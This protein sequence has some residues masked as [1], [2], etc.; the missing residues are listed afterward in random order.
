MKRFLSLAIVLAI[1]CSIFGT[2]PAFAKEDTQKGDLLANG[3][4]E[5][6]GTPYAFWQGVADNTRISTSITHGGER[7]M[8]LYS[9]DATRQIVIYDVEG[10]I[11]GKNYVFSVYL[12]IKQL[13]NL[14]EIDNGGCIKIE[15]YDKEGNGLPGSEWGCFNGKPEK[16]FEC[17]L[18]SIAPDNANTAKIQLR[19]ECGG[20]I[21]WDDASFVG[22]VPTRI[23]EEIKNKR[24][25]AAST[26]EHSS[27]LLKQEQQKSA[28]IQLAPGIANAIKNPGFEELTADGKAPVNWRG[29]KGVWGQVTFPTEEE[30]HSG[31]R[32]AKITYD[33]PNDPNIYFPY[34]HHLITDNLVGGTD[35]VLSAWV[36]VKDMA[37]LK[38]IVFKWE[39][40][41]GLEANSQNYIAAGDSSEYILEEG[42]WHQVKFSFTLP[43][44][45][46]TLHLYIRSTGPGTVYYDDI[47]FGPTG[48]SAAMNFYTKDTFYYTEDK[49]IEAFA[50]INYINHPIEDGNVVDFV[51]KDG[52]SVVAE[53]TIPAVPSV[54]AEFDVMTLAEKGKKYTIS[55]TY[56]KAD[57]TVI[58][59]SNEKRIYRYDRPTALNEKGEYIDENG[60][61]IDVIYL[62]GGFEEFFD[63]YQKAGITVIRIDDI[64]T[65]NPGKIDEIRKKLDAAHE[66]GLKVLY[67]LYGHAAGHP[68]QIPTTKLLVEEFKDHPAIFGWM[69]VDEPCY[70]VG[71]GR[72]CQTYTEILEYLEEGYRVIREIDPVHPVY[73]IEST[74]VALSYEKAF[75]YV[76]VAGIDIYPTPDV[77]THRTSQAARRAVNAVYGEKPVWNLGYASEWMGWIPTEEEFRMSVISAFW[78]GADGAGFYVEKSIA[79]SLNEALIKMN[80][81]GERHQLFN[82]FVREKSP[83]FSE[84][85]GY[86]YWMRSW[87]DE[88]KLYI[89]LREHKNDGKE[90]PVSFKVKSTNGLIELNGFNARLVN[91]PTAP[92]VSS[93]D[94]T[95]NLTLKPLETATYVI[96]LPAGTDASLLDKPIYNDLGN[97]TW[98]IDAIEKT[99][100]RGVSNDKGVG[101]YAPGEN[102]T[103]G[104]FAMYLVRT[105]G[106]TEYDEG[107]QFTDV[108]PNAYYAKEIA[109]GKKAGILKGTGDGTYHPEEPISRQDLMVICARGLRSLNKISTANPDSALKNFSD[110]GLIADYALVEVASMV[111]SGKITGNADMTINPLGNTTR[112]EAAVIMSRIL[113]Y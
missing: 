53:Q 77:A 14:A 1:I 94:S 80:E 109:I 30:A 97:H 56:K 28:D 41:S 13:L 50:D 40:Y 11:P 76:D 34:M 65:S 23:Y 85:I 93:A 12:Y 47:E 19:M 83:V 81:S 72:Q 54:K 60:N 21:F 102:I 26:W 49:V 18:E 75:Q 17:T 107:D 71:M 98:A 45:T 10:V 35:Y 25:L 57:G 99:A 69:M 20:E 112:A 6:L 59:E 84:Y 79:P 39:A 3:D 27:E 22:E 55:A 88:G 111:A 46:A 32:S 29:Y 104:D 110:M 105:L 5:L 113:P 24:E 101:I 31:L 95:F 7:A 52:G 44:N 9:A 91:G 16:W 8:R 61:P 64:N 108:D 15:W 48:S 87:V 70:Q 2:L 63:D 103:R 42:Q 51:I 82:H 92:V 100:T 96:D 58:Q 4:M 78:G 37:A 36:K 62:Y 67:Q 90:T 89:L 73:N 86:D 43:E 38:G 106:L 66:H 68:F 74:A 33:D